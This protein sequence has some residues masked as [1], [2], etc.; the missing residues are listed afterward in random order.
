MQPAMRN[1]PKVINALL[2]H[3]FDAVATARAIEDNIQA[4]DPPLTQTHL[5]MFEIEIDTIAT[6]LKR[7]VN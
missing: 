7:C 5:Q 3:L 1:E 6:I 4:G 2:G